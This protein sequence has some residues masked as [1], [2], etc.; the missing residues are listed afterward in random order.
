MFSTKI[1]FFLVVE[2]PSLQIR[3]DP[4]TGQK[5]LKG[6]GELQIEVLR[7]RLHREYKL[8]VFMGPLRVC[9]FKILFILFF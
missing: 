3:E 6:M 8:D 5:V 7:E 1:T 4:N 2:D 9:N